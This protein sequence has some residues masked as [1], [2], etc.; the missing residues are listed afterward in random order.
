MHVCLQ[1]G[2]PWWKMFVDKTDKEKDEGTK[3]TLAAVEMLEG[4][5][6]EI[7]QLMTTTISH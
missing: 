2:T 1:L 6:Q 5:L 3:Q 7:C 4:A